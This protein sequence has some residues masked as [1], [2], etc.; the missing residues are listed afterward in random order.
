[1]Y[2]WPVGMFAV[3]GLPG[4]VVEPGTAHN[5]QPFN[6]EFFLY[7]FYIFFFY[8]YCNENPIYVFLFWELRAWSPSPAI[9]IFTLQQKSS[10]CI[11]LLGIARAARR[12]RGNQVPRMISSPAIRIFFSFQFTLQ[13]HSHLCIPLLAIACMISSPSIRTFIYL[14]IF[15]F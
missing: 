12:G 14:F 3:H 11:P 1:M 15:F 13:Q 5:L 8:V 7:F 10:L 6:Q 9:R 2:S 4:E